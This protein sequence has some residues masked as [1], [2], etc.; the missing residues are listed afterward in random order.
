MK[1]IFPIA[2][3]FELIV[4]VVLFRSAVKDFLWTHP[5]W[6]SFL[7]AVPVIALPI[8]AYL[9]LLHSG[10]ANRLRA[11]ANKLRADLDAERNKHLE[12]IA[13][14]TERPATQA[15]RNADTLRKHLRA[16][17]PVTEEQGS[18]PDSPE[19][20][21]VSEDNIVTLFMPRSFSSSSAW[22]VQVHCSDLEI[23]NIPQGSC[24]LRLKV[25]KRYGSAVPLGEI[26]KWEDHL[27][28]A[29]A[30]TFAKGGTACYAMY[31]KPGSPETRSLHVYASSDGANSF[32]L[33]AS[34]GEKAAGNNE[35]ISK[36]FMVL[37]IEYQ[38]A[39]F[40]RS[41]F[42]TGNTPHHLFIS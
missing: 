13:K 10:E 16:K 19:I 15:E 22:C 3:V 32:L 26:T 36:R 7:A 23:T 27:L 29:A 25:N 41:G 42:G 5:W 33:E 39:G 34:T 20:V 24:P 4:V 12:Q 30:P 31:G 35:E 38:A 8:L 6:H 17:V 37:Q 21:E 28:A 18:W 9:E 11:E 1:R 40:T 2:L 14:H